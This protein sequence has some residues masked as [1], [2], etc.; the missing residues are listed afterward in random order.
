MF[1]TCNTFSWFLKN[2]SRHTFLFLL[3]TVH[4]QGLDVRGS[5]TS[6]FTTNFG[7]KALTGVGGLGGTWTVGVGG[8]SWSNAERHKT[9]ARM[10]IPW[11]S[12]RWTWNIYN[13]HKSITEIVFMW[14]AIAKH[15]PPKLHKEHEIFSAINHISIYYLHHLCSTAHV[16]S[17]G[18]LHQWSSTW[19]L[20]HNNIKK[21]IHINI[22]IHFLIQYH[23][24]TIPMTHQIL[25]K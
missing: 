9:R 8:Y 23:L 4:S 2:F 18:S 13:K 5:T 22:Y 1:L 17:K 3:T 7:E 21:T 11:S 12:L 10:P 19:Y 6:P 14:Y 15:T 24:I 25:S 20:Q 16:A